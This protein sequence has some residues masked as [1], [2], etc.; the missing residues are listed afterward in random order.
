[1]KRF[2]MTVALMCLL[3]VSV[4]AGDIPCG[5]FPP[6]PAPG[7]VPSVGE[8]VVLTIISLLPR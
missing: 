3:S 2:L 8:M 6:P 7:E 5:G 1:M 4:L